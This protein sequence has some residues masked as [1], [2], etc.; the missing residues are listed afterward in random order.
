MKIPK[1]TGGDLT[2]HQTS[3]EK[4]VILKVLKK[5]WFR[6]EQKYKVC[7]SSVKDEQIEYHYGIAYENELS[8]AQK[9]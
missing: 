3:S 8:L 2:Y 1:F 5:R 7:W 6:H 4:I 9:G